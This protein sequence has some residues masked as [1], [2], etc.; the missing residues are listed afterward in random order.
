MERRVRMLLLS[1]KRYSSNSRYVGK[2]G[3]LGQLRPYLWP[4][5]EDSRKRRIEMASAFT[6]MLASKVLTIQVPYIFK[7]AI[8]RLEGAQ[9]LGNLVENANVLSMAGTLL[10]G[11]TS[12]RIA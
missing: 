9:Q 5:N 11:Y 3:L 6:L 8:D 7:L 1:H 10:L 4:K 2:L 12:A